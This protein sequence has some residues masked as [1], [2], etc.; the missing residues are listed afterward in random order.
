MRNCEEIYEGCIRENT[1]FKKKTNNEE[2]SSVK[3]KG[4]F[5]KLLH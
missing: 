4:H 3:E 2:I 1:V 5:L